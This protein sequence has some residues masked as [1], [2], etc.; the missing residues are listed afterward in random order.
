MIARDRELDLTPDH[1]ITRLDV[2]MR[3]QLEMRDL[4][5]DAAD[6]GCALPAA[7]HARFRLWFILGWPGFPSLVAIYALMVMKPARLASMLEAALR[8]Q[9]RHIAGAVKDADDDDLVGA[10]RIIEGVRTVKYDAQARSEHFAGWSYLRE[11]A[12]RF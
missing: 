12:Q 6:R 8:G 2:V 10:R 9:R 7:Y 4:S 1:W 3:L 11:L 5:R